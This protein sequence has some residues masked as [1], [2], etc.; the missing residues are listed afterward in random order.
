M[1]PVEDLSGVDEIRRN[2]IFYDAEQYLWGT[3]RLVKSPWR[4][5]PVVAMHPERET[6]VHLRGCDPFE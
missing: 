1:H 4:W 6:V 3:C 5:L 2:F